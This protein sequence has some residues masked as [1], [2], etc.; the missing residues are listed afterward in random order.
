MQETCHDNISAH[1][2]CDRQ[3]FPHSLP[4]N[5]LWRFLFFMNNISSTF[6][7]SKL[8]LRKLCRKRAMT[9][10]QSI[11]AATGNFFNDTATTEIYTLSLHYALPILA[12]FPNPN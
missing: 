9:I 10:F 12:R 2:S 4:K 6:P 3:K 5:I 8:N 1:Y 11:T 7:E